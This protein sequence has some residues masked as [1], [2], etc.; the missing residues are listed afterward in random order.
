[1]K[2]SNT[3]LHKLKGFKFGLEMENYCQWGTRLNS[4]DGY[5]FH[6]EHDDVQEIKTGICK[7]YNGILSFTKFITNEFGDHDDF[8][9]H[10]YP[11]T[12]RGTASCHIHV[13]P[14]SYEL[15]LKLYKLINVHQFFFKNSPVTW[16][17][18]ETFSR[19]HSVKQDW[20]RF[21]TASEEDYNH[22]I[23]HDRYT[24]ALTPNSLGTLEMR[25]NDVPKSFNQLALFYYLI[26]S[27]KNLNFSHLLDL[28]FINVKGFNDLD[29]VTVLK[30]KLIPF[31][32]HEPN[33]KLYLESYE[34]VLDFTS[35]LIESSYPKKTLFYDFYKGDY[36]TFGKFIRNT[37]KTDLKLFHTYFDDK[38]KAKDWTT[39]L[40]ENFKRRIPKELIKAKGG[41]F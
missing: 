38:L 23:R 31:S 14:E 1:M 2:L 17:N 32:I 7:N 16:R 36:V 21:Q 33:D 6:T 37:Y 20:C 30:Q 25:Y 41:W 27:A 12:K 4:A 40:L 39:I 18:Q 11:E 28:P 22:T 13:S 19:R 8:Y 5:N 34:D 35:K 26:F 10:S 24:H 29:S 3:N 9:L 15:Y